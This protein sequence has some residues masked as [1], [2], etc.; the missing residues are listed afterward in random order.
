MSET[1]P[2]LR[3]LLRQYSYREGD[4]VLASGKRSRYYVDVRRTSLTAEGAAL[5]GEALWTLIEE[6]GWQPDAVGGMS[7]GADPLTTA[8]ALA[9]RADGTTVSCFLVR[10]EPKGHG[11]GKQVEPG[12][13]L[14]DGASVVVLEDTVT[15]GGSTLR[16][17]EAVRSA[18]YHVLGA[19]AVVDRCEGGAERLAEA[20]VTLHS[21]FAVG[22][23]SDAP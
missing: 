22:A 9:A 17:I 21:L 11:A 4:F 6:A 18:G 2:R 10:K 8:T 13:D 15:T 12:G 5:I 3:T 7:L 16:A 19:A 1:L 14:A 23:L 20:G